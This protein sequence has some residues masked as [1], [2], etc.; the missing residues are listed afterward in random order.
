MLLGELSVGDEGLQVAAV[1]AWRGCWGGARTP[2]DTP[3]CLTSFSQ[4]QT[5]LLLT[6]KSINDELRRRR[7]HSCHAFHLRGVPRRHCMRLCRMPPVFRM[8][9]LFRAAQ[10][11]C[12]LICH[13]V[14]LHSYNPCHESTIQQLT[15]RE[16]VTNKP[17]LYC[18]GEVRGW[19]SVGSNEK[20]NG[21]G[22]VGGGRQRLW[23]GYNCPKTTKAVSMKS[24]L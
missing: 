21:G 11:V 19:I 22:G 13:N 7:R 24:I 16:G 23:L 3:A 9:S 4:Q 20:R 17:A 5:D 1:T 10:T 8:P 2:Q 6:A 14:R 12:T 15:N 18:C